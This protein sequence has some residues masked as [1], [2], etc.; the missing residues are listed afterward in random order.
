MLLAAAASGT[1]GL[2]AL[3]VGTVAFATALAVAARLLAP[4]ESRLA[5]AALRVGR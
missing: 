5:L 2:A 4:D 3:A 1:D